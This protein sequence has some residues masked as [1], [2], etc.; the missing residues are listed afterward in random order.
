MLA[1]GSGFLG[2]KLA[3]RLETEGHTAI[4][5][6]RRPSGAGNQI[7]WQP[8]GSAGALPRHLDGVDAIVNLAGEGIADKRWT[9][10][11][12]D[13]LRNSRILS[14]RT[15]VRAVAGVRAS[16]E[17]VHQRIGDRLLRPAR[18]RARHRIDAAGRR[19]FWRG[20]ASNGNRRRAW[21]SRRRRGWRSSAPASR[22]IATAARSRK[23]CCRSSSVSARRS[24]SGDQYMPWIH[25]DDWT[26]MVSWLIHERSRQRRVQRHGAGAGHQSH[27][28]AHAR[29]RAASPGRAA[30]AGIRAARRAR[31]DGVDARP[32]PARPAR[33]RG[34]AWISFHAPR[35]SSRRS[36]ASTSDQTGF[37][38]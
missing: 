10:A 37:T 26:A 2:R 1:G 38:S 16:A 15:L 7:A 23:C 13:A 20:S 31:R 22:S 27:V 3:Q 14:T 6:S 8:D 11:R 35:R 30:C 33:R 34:A 4:T 12:K 18:R 9:A 29:P 21:S 25:A 28:H 5:L 17:G 32:W 19:T 24:G 36:R